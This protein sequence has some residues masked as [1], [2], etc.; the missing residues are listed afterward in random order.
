MKNKIKIDLM[1]PSVSLNDLVHSQYNGILSYEVPSKWIYNNTLPESLKIHN[2]T[3]LY[4]MI[5]TIE[6]IVDN[7]N[8]TCIQKIYN[9]EDDNVFYRLGYP[10]GYNIDLTANSNTGYTF[11]NWKNDSFDE[12]IMDNYYSKFDLNNIFLKDDTVNRAI[13]KNIFS[14]KGNIKNGSYLDIRDTGYYVITGALQHAPSYIQ[15]HDIEGILE[16]YN[17]NDKIYQVLT[18]SAN[19]TSNVPI[20]DSN[21]TKI[22]ALFYSNSEPFVVNESYNHAISL[23]FRSISKYTGPGAW[24]TA[25][26][27]HKIYAYKHWYDSVEKFVQENAITDV[28]SAY[29]TT[30]SRYYYYNTPLNADQDIPYSASIMYSSPNFYNNTAPTFTNTPVKE[31]TLYRKLLKFK[32]NGQAIDIARWG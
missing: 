26:S 8:K 14:Y 16:V 20:E 18:V 6:N 9:V 4:N 12:S 24:V 21:L 15:G 29:T 19:N 2:D 17:T 28:Y 30:Y 13:F 5:F 10:A 22:K 7:N 1:S 31:I 23:H 25:E 3:N 11:T 27:I 32:R